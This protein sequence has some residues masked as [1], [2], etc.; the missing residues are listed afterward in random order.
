MEWIIWSVTPVSK[1]QVSLPNAALLIGL[2][3]NME[4][5]LFKQI[6]SWNGSQENILLERA[7]GFI[8]ELTEYCMPSLVPNVEA[9]A[10]N[11][12]SA[13]KAV[14][15]TVLKCKE[16]NCSCWWT[17]CCCCYVQFQSGTVLLQ[18]R[19]DWPWKVFLFACTLEDSIQVCS[20]SP[21]CD[22]VCHSGCK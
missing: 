21:L 7:L 14:S 12:E 17:N 19:P 1:T 4:C 22:Q 15:D 18:W 6:F 9:W 13:K 10:G 3:A 16:K 5:C 20:T 2:T 8:A 11:W